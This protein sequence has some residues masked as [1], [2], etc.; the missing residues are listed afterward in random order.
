MRRLW[1]QVKTSQTFKHILPL[2]LPLRH[3][4][5]RPR[6]DLPNVPRLRVH[7]TTHIHDGLRAKPKQLSYERLVAALT[8]RV[9]DERGE[10]G[11]K[12]RDGAKDLSRVARAEGHFVREAVECRVV[13]CKADR[14]RRELDAGDLCESRSERKREEARAAVCVYEV[15]RGQVA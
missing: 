13:R 1:K 4:V 14:V 6:D 3:L 12:V 9:H 8:R 15:C 11:R 5:R 2:P 7:V 10:G